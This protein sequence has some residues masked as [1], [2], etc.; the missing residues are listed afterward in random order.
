MLS[1][2]NTTLF[3]SPGRKEG[4]RA[5]FFHPMTGGVMH[6]ATVKKVHNY[7][8]GQEYTVEFDNGNTHRVPSNN[9]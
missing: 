7:K 5:R 6:W 4:D 9:F 8:D 3:D 2:Y 1:I